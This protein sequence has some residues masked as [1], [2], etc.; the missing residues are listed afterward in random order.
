MSEEEYLRLVDEGLK[1]FQ[2]MKKAEAAYEEHCIK[3]SG[4]NT[5]II[6]STKCNELHKALIAAQQKWQQAGEAEAEAHR[7]WKGY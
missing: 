7:R 6:K 2:E 5:E 3:A 1:A 4:I